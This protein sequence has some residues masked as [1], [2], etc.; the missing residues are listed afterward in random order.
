MLLAGE[1]NLR[2]VTAFPKSQSAL[3]LL[4]GAPAPVSEARLRELKLKIE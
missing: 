2:E 4:T 3:D 1:D